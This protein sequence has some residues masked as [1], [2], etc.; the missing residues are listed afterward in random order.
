[1]PSVCV[2]P[3]SQLCV[4]RCSAQIL[5]PS[6][7]FRLKQRQSCASHRHSSEAQKFFRKELLSVGRPP[8]RSLAHGSGSI[9]GD[10][11]IRGFDGSAATAAVIAVI[12][13]AAAAQQIYSRE[14]ES[15]CARFQATVC[16]PEKALTHGYI[17]LMN[18]SSSGSSRQISTAAIHRHPS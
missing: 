12:V 5:V 2:L 1:M 17:T 4:S 15:Q 9:G 8:V 3:L 13:A 11:A 18:S 14:P 16:L 7:C 10:G 6:S